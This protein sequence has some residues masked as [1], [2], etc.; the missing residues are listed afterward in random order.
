[1]YGLI[2]SILLRLGQHTLT[3]KQHVHVNVCCCHCAV[4]NVLS[5]CLFVF[6]MIIRSIKGVNV[7]YVL[8]AC[9]DVLSASASPSHTLCWSRGSSES[10]TF[11]PTGKFPE[12]SVLCG[13]S[14]HEAGQRF[15]LLYSDTGS[16]GKCLGMAGKVA[17]LCALT[18][19]PPPGNVRKRKKKCLDWLRCMSVS[20][21]VE[22]GQYDRET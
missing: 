16:L 9:C 4:N 5:T 10:D 17:D 6:Y 14:V 2:N 13:Q 20:S 11:T 1:M 3:W 15:F 12:D 19:S 22:T 18:Y 8:T 21:K 7:F